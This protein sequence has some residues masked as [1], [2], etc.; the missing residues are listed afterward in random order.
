MI[1]RHM[2][3]ILVTYAWISFLFVSSCHPE[4]DAEPRTLDFGR[5]TIEVPGS[6]EPVTKT[7][8]DSYVGGIRAGGLAE[9]EFDL[10]RYASDLNVDHNTHETFWT[11]IDGRKAKIVKPRGGAKGI[12][13][14]YIESIDEEGTLRFQMSSSNARPAVREQLIEAFETI[15]FRSIDEIPPFVP[16][17]VRE[18]I[19]SLQAEPVRNPPASVWQFEYGGA[20]VY[21]V[22]AY[23][24]DIPSMLYDENCTFICSPDGGFTGSGDGNCTAELE[25][26]LLV[27]QD[28][29][30]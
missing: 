2:R 5:F 24:C 25:R 30:K 27:W 15:T 26:G 23:C 6:W 19:E 21:Y 18:L 12:T 29:R 22:P 8:F 3:R 11:T 14:V 13:G 7:G 10:G 1:F 4:H 20:V 9:I 28:L 16:D 17:C